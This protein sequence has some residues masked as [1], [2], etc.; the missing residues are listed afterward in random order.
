MAV[1]VPDIRF[2]QE[3]GQYA[4]MSCVL[5]WN[6]V[7]LLLLMRE[8]TWKWSILW[9]IS[10]AIAIYSYYG[11]ALIIRSHY[12]GLLVCTISKRQWSRFFKLATATAFAAHLSFHLP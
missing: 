8:G 2:A 1:L 11:A 6:L 9:G 3:A 4:L 12:P 10:A 5:S 7:F